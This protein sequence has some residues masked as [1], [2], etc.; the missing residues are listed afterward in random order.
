M[1]SIMERVNFLSWPPFSL[2]RFKSGL[3]Q[4]FLYL[5]KPFF[6]GNRR[7]SKF[8]FFHLIAILD[9][10]LFCLLL[11]SLIVMESLRLPVYLDYHS[12]TPVDQRVV[13]AMLPYFTQHYGNAASRSH[14]YG[15]QASEAVELS[16]SKVA[17]LINVNA[18][19]I[20]FSSGTTESLNMAIKGLAE[21]LS[22]KGKHIV[23]VTTEHLAVLDP[24][25]W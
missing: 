23:T 19:E 12:T 5:C 3:L 25:K 6:F 21:N 24:L 4:V 15:W 14:P 10:N 22:H 18:D 20:Y 1:R 7:K 13:E 11:V 2:Q 8:P 17:Q 16:R 9:K